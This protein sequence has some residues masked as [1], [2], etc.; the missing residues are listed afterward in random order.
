MSTSPSLPSLVQL[1]Q[2]KVKPTGLRN[3]I[4][5]EKVPF[6][7]ADGR[8]ILQGCPDRIFSGPSPRDT[9]ELVPASDNL[10]CLISNF[11]SNLGKL[12]PVGR[13]QLMPI[14]VVVYAD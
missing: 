12:V 11:S 14:A 8:F 13:H 3:G 10:Q 9:S 6:I 5:G 4:P 1:P 2:D 7:D